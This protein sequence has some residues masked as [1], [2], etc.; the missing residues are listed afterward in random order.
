MT[1]RL[2]PILTLALLFTAS[3]AVASDRPQ[4]EY[5]VDSTHSS[6]EFTIT[7]W[8]VTRQTGVFRE[9]GGTI[10]LDPARPEGGTVR[11]R[12]DA[13]SLDTRNQSRDDAVKSSDFLDVER[14]RWMTFQSTAI[15]RNRSGGFDVAGDLTIRGVTRR[16]VAPVRLIGIA[17]APG[18]GELASFETSFI[19]N[20]RDFG[21]DGT[22]WSGG[23]AILG[24]EVTV[25]L[26]IVGRR[27]R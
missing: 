11:V 16:V 14:H 8:S 22:R 12:I 5:R 10:A 24:D 3:S 6:V 25:K 23:Q 1:K 20:R 18:N 7:K 19:I 2:L 4:R 17:E 26:N 9:L 15:E 27:T 13:A 21:V